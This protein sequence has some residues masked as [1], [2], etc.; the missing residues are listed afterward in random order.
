MSVAFMRT[1]T[2]SSTI[3]GEVLKFIGGEGSGLLAWTAVNDRRAESLIEESVAKI[4]PG[5]PVL[6]PE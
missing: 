2:S 6:T 5:R 4:R 3:G 1:N